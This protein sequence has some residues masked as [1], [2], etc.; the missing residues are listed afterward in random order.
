MHTKAPGFKA[1]AMTKSNVLAGMENSLKLLGLQQVETYFLH[2]PDTETPIE[3]TL[4]AIQEIYLAAKFKK[5]RPSYS[6]P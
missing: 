4:E 3:E 2:S 1:G 5:V 6:F